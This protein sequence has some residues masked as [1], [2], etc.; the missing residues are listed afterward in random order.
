MASLRNFFNKIL[1]SD[2]IYS[3]EDI[4][5]MSNDE[6][7]A[8]EKAIDYQMANLGVP[9]NADLA[10]SDDV[11][12]VHAYTRDDG[13][14]VR[15]H[16]RSKHGRSN[17]A[18]QSEIES[19]T[20]AAA[21]LENQKADFSEVGKYNPFKYINHYVNQDKDDARELA[22][23]YLVKPKNAPK[24]SEYTYMKPGFEKLINNTYALEGNKKIDKSWPGIV[25]REN[26]TLSRNASNSKEMQKQIRSQFDSK[27]GKFKSDKLEIDYTQD[28]NLHLSIG[29]GTILRPYIDDNGYF[30]GILFDKYDF[31]NYY[32][33]DS[34]YYDN[35]KITAA[36]N[37]FSVL[38]ASR[39]AK[40][41]YLL[42]PIK[43]KW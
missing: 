9:Q 38:G 2:R 5:E 13:T 26:S 7:K 23:I 32:Y 21:P 1:D 42:A 12:Y 34:N 14:K 37:V 31:D 3:R 43:F 40:S 27:S 41:Y 20:G 30:H 36:S 29:H 35:Y 17:N 28:A 6:F 25:Y 15:A 4:G 10:N 18:L 22:D 39:L 16:Y 24:S 33:S 19:A 11:V 8:N